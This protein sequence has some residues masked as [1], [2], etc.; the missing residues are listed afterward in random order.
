MHNRL[1]EGCICIF[2]D[3]KP[4]FDVTGDGWRRGPFEGGEEVFSKEAVFDWDL[5]AGWSDIWAFN[6]D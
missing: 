6:G 1:S 2:N 3:K 4:L 5:G